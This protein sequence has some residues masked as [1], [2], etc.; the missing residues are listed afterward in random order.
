MVSRHIAA[1][2]AAFCTGCIDEAVSETI[3]RDHDGI[4]NESDNCEKYN[5]TQGDRDGDGLG[6][7]CE[8]GIAYDF[9]SRAGWDVPDG[10]AELVTFRPRDGW[11][12]IHTGTNES[13][14]L[15]FGSS[16]DRPVAGDFNGDAVADLGVITPEGKLVW[17]TVV[18][19]TPT[20][21]PLP[22]AG[23]TTNEL[24]FADYDGDSITDA[25]VFDASTGTWT[26]VRS[27]DGDV[28]TEALAEPG[29]TPLTGDMNGDS[30]ADFIA[31]RSR[32]GEVDRWYRWSGVDRELEVGIGGFP[33]DIPVAV[34][35]EGDG[36]TDIVTWRAPELDQEPPYAYFFR[37][38]VTLASWGIRGDCPAAFNHFRSLP[39][40]WVVFR[41][42]GIEQVPRNE[43]MNHWYVTDAVRTVVT[44]GSEDDE[45][46][47]LGVSERCSRIVR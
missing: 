44:M 12:Y 9:G 41:R 36:R 27:S 39:A 32:P 7:A 21:V 10:R 40:E 43:R 14:E 17:R 5:P 25:A 45:L 6:D 31:Y 35:V 42:N 24:V 4:A 18:D 16:N 37:V 22:G 33:G 13:I 29:D 26:V 30:R 8:Q 19:A 20:T 38:D 46:I 34:D 2:L 28:L 15:L 3:D 23:W 1:A 11:W 47:P